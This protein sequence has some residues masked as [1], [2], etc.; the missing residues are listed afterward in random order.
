MNTVRMNI[1]LPSEI[2]ELL[3][4]VKNKSNFI[5]EAVKERIEREERNQLIKELKEGY[6]IR[7]SEDNLLALEWDMTTGDGID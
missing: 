1:T 3:K 4:S 7:K 2:A 6:K 5:A